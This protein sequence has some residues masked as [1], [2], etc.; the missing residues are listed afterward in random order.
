MA[1]NSERMLWVDG[2]KGLLTVWIILFHYSLAFINRGFIGFATNYA[3]EEFAV[4][5]IQNLPVSIFVN[6]SFPLYV[7]LFLIAFIPAYQFFGDK[8]EARI[9]RHARARYFRLMIPTFLACC[10]TFLLHHAGL[11]MHVEAGKQ[12]GIVWLQEIMKVDFS[13]PSLLYEGLIKAYVSGSQFI[14]VS[15]VMGYIFIG[16]FLSYAILLLFC[17]TEKRTPLYL[18]LFV[19]LFCY[20]QTY[21]CFLL[22][23]VAADAVRKAEAGKGYAASPAVSAGLI[24]AGLLSAAVPPLW[25]PK[26]LDVITLYGIGAALL[27]AGIAGSGTARRFLEAKPLQ[28]LARY[29]FSAILI[30]I[31][32]MASVSCPQYLKMTNAGVSAA[33]AVSAVFLAAIPVQILAAF[34]FQKLTVP[35]TSFVVGKVRDRSL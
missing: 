3:E 7:F 5:Y 8:S 15:W 11:L 23:I 18:G 19:Y 9:M 17:Q 1:Q 28:V 24:A 16:S 10:I 25:L 12:S 33:A 35:L 14:S 20:D 34:L 13:F 6:S 2:L 27:A 22:G 21:L 32:V 30:H 31:P 29:S 4:R 26:P